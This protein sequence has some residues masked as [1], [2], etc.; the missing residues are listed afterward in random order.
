M[1]PDRQAVFWAAAVAIVV[2]LVSYLNAALLPFVLGAVIAYFLDPIVGK[3]QRVGFGRTLAS[4]LV[5]EAK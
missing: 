3:L 1:R 4:V 2:A 5:I